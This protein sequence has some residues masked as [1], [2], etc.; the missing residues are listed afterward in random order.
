MGVLWCSQGRQFV[1]EYAARGSKFNFHGMYHF[2]FTIDSDYYR[3][4]GD[5]HTCDLAYV[6]HDRK[7]WW[8]PRDEQLSTAMQCY[9]SAFARSGTPNIHPVDS[10]CADRS[11]AQWPR[12]VAT[13]DDTLV[14]DDPIITDQHYRKAACDFWDTIGYDKTMQ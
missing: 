6:F 5:F 7:S 8:K 9:F 4:F 13:K 2:N 14:F 1:R 10:I 3:Q 12:Y 11:L